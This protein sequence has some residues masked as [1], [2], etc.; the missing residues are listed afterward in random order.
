MITE[1]NLSEVIPNSSHNSARCG[2]KGGNSRWQRKKRKQQRKNQRRKR[3]TKPQRLITTLNSFRVTTPNFNPGGE[4]IFLPVFFAIQ[5]ILPAPLRFPLRTPCPPC[6]VVLSCSTISRRRKTLHAL[7]A[8]CFVKIFNP[9]SILC[10]G[11]ILFKR[12][13]SNWK[14]MSQRRS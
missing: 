11:L 7:P 3:G 13:I 8:S 12:T 14:S 5:A 1:L 4:F 6:E 10:C 9:R 2:L